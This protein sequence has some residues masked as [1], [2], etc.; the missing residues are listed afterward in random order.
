MGEP[1]FAELRTKKQL[2]YIVQ[3]SSSG[4]GRAPGTVRG[5]TVRLLSNRFSPSAMQDELGLFFE[6]QKQVFSS[7]TQVDLS[8]R[9]AS[10]IQVRVSV[11]VGIIDRIIDIMQLE[12]KLLQTQTLTLNP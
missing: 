10:I 7:L 11:R 6:S 9:T 2:G 12:Y 5:L 8:S 3:L 4:Y 1:L